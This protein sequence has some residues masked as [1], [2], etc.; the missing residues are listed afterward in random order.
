MNVLMLSFEDCAGV[1]YRYAE[2]LNHY[3]EMGFSARSVSFVKSYMNYPIH[4]YRPSTNELKKLVEWADVVHAFDRRNQWNALLQKKPLV[5]SYHGIFYRSSRHKIDKMDMERVITSR[6]CTTVDMTRYGLELVPIPAPMGLRDHGMH[7]VRETSPDRVVDVSHAPTKLGRKG[8]QYV[9][10]AEAMLAHRE[11][12]IIHKVSNAEC[13][14]RKALSRIFVEQIGPGIDRL[15]NPALAMCGMNVLEAWVIGLPVICSVN[16]ELMPL[17]TERFGDDF[18][19]MLC[20]DPRGLAGLIENMLKDEN[21]RAEYG[22][23]GYDHV[24]NC[25]TEAVIAS[26]LAGIYLYAIEVGA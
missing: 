2:A 24:M 19:F 4:V 25:H 16:K 9:R 5:V 14:E 23:R 3:P 18:P 15:G 20:E 13:L 22:A 7:H 12:D 17:F 8:V 6:M 26:K 10:D 21:L 11:F 1:S